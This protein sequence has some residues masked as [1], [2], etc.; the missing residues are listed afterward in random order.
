MVMEHAT[1]G[2]EP[3]AAGTPQPDPLNQALSAISHEIKNP[4]ASLKLN[5]QMISRAIERGQP[6]RAASAALLSQAVDQLDQIASALSEMA[7]AESGRLTLALRCVD[8]GALLQRVTSEAAEAHHQ[9]IVVELPQQ[10]QA[11]L[12]TQADPGRIEQALVYLLANALNYSPDQAPITLAARRV[13]HH[14]RVEARDQGPGIE[15]QDRA[16]IFEPFYRGATLPQRHTGAGL[17]LS[18]AIARRIIALH[19]GEIGAESPADS[20]SGHGAVVWFTLPALP[21]S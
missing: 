7:R 21:C 5:A 9:R 8:V 2:A 10:R 4:L 19:G 13:G 11:P 6:P 14:L 1:E 18:L 20:R 16:R 17:G 12:L 15:P 3:S